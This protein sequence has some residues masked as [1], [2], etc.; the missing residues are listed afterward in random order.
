[1][2]ISRPLRRAPASSK[3][4]TSAGNTTRS[5]W[6][7][8]GPGQARPTR[9]D[10]TTLPT[11]GRISRHAAALAQDQARRALRRQIARAFRVRRAPGRRTQ[12][13]KSR[14]PCCSVC[15]AAHSSF[16][17]PCPC[18]ATSAHGVEGVHQSCMAGGC[19]SRAQQNSDVPAGRSPRLA[20]SALAWPR[21]SDPGR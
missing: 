10:L 6:G 2:P 19:G 9:A 8:A 14:C 13:D 5:G 15:L 21:I 12:Q 1:M 18:P 17:L 16:F 4:T 11:V 3:A 20:R 7:N